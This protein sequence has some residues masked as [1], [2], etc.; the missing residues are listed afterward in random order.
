MSWMLVTSS[1]MIWG[2]SCHANENIHRMCNGNFVPLVPGAHALACSLCVSAQEKIQ[3]NKLQERA[4]S[5]LQ[6]EGVGPLKTF[7][8][9]F[10]YL[11]LLFLFTPSFPIPCPFSICTSLMFGAGGVQELEPLK[12][13]TDFSNNLFVSHLWHVVIL[14]ANSEPE[15]FFP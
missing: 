4:G 3:G 6:A 15:G 2:S 10:L 11:G 5:C 14:D 13:C 8:G 9:L 1:G 12:I 7:I